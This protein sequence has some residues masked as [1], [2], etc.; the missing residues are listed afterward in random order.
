LNS[1]KKRIEKENQIFRVESQ[2]SNGYLH[3]TFMTLYV[4]INV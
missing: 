3:A 4:D 1:K 2:V